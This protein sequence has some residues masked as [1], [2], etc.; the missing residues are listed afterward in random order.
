MVTEDK[1]EVYIKRV[2][3]ELC[4]VGACICVCVC[5]FVSSIDAHLTRRKVGKAA[6]SAKVV[7]KNK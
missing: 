1:V 2:P 3:Q 4:A 7:T 6:K 5:A